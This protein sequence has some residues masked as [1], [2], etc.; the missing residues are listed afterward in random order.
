MPTSIPWAGETWNPWQGCTKVSTECENCYM[1]LEKLRY[2]QNPEMVVKSTR[3]TFRKP[4]RIA[5]GTVVFT[6]S[7]G[8]WFH[9]HADQWRK[10]AW[11]II[12][13]CQHL[14]FVILTKRPERIADMLPTDWSSLTY[15][16][17]CLGITAGNQELFDKRW[18]YLREIDAAAY[19]ISH[20]PALGMIH[21][22]EDFIALGK[23]YRAGIIAGGESGYGNKIR[24]SHALWFRT[25]RD[26]CI[27]HDIPFFF[28][29]WGEYVQGIPDNHGGWILL[30]GGYTATSN[31]EHKWAVGG[32]SFRIGRRN[33]GIILDS[34]TYQQL[35]FWGIPPQPMLDLQ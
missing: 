24:P 12:A 11:S 17:V 23:Q 13:D 18:A 5:P 27:H 26:Q 35:P 2:G 33:T 10:E 20:E 14:R 8:D 25:D 30:N 28:K 22:P 7:W 1:F 21:Y 16:N 31:N 19:L 29:G 4:Y 32:S 9:E 15:A 6:C 34:R 3:Q